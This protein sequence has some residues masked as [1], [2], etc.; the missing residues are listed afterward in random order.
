MKI[1]FVHFGKRLPQHLL[2]NI[3]RCLNLFPSNQIVLITNQDCKV[4]DFE[5]LEIYR[6]TKSDDWYELDKGLSHP[7]DFR[8]N[9]WFTSIA[10]FLAIKSYMEKYPEALIHVESDVILA[11][12]FPFASFSSFDCDL[13]FPIVS[14]T[15]GIASTLYVRSYM[16]AQKLASFSLEQVKSDP[17]TTDMIILRKFFEAFPNLV[18]ILPIGPIKLNC[19]RS[20]LDDDLLCQM[21]SSFELLGGIID[22]ADIGYHTYGVDPRNSRGIKILRKGIETNYLD[23]S[24]T[25]LMYSESR[26]F[27]NFWDSNLKYSIPIFSLHIHSKDLKL[28]PV[29]KSSKYLKYGVKRYLEKE[30]FEFVPRIFLM[31]LV[32]ALKRR[33]VFAYEE[34]KNV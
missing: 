4:K 10:R 5:N 16:A 24:K 23:V 6:Y 27:L 2:L 32:A 21:G 9:F 7:K 29:S 34:I 3:S 12:D 25:K 31:T 33:L 19:Y 26:N 22:G 30:S 11:R 28:F 1:V 14:L 13:A 17:S 20:F 18:R 15:Q 8:E